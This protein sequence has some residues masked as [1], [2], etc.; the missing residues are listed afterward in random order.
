MQGLDEVLAV[1]RLA[2]K[3]PDSTSIPVN[4]PRLLNGGT[5]VDLQ[6]P[7][8]DPGASRRSGISGRANCA[9]VAERYRSNELLA[10][11]LWTTSPPPVTCSLPHYPR[12]P[13]SQSAREGR[14]NASP[15]RLPGGGGGQW[16]DLDGDIAPLPARAGKP[17]R[18]AAAEIEAASTAAGTT[19]LESSSHILLHSWRSGEALGKSKETRAGKGAAAECAAGPGD[20]QNKDC[21]S[22]NKIQSTQTLSLDGNG[23]NGC[24]IDSNSCRN[25]DTEKRIH[26][27]NSRSRYKSK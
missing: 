25:N 10:V 8:R 1:C 7:R 16:W 18:V 26:I 5:A 12:T 24:N 4:P 21:W 20:G 9:A 11:D 3:P 6:Q 19:Q 2:S 15:A 13:A 27:G 23:G 14:P 17:F 22:G